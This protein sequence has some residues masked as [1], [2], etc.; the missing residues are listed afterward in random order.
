VLRGRQQPQPGKEPIGPSSKPRS[1]C[2]TWKAGALPVASKSER[3]AS[4]LTTFANTWPHCKRLRNF[5]PLARRPHTDTPT[6]V[7]CM[8]VCMYCT[9]LYCKFLGTACMYCMYIQ[10]VPAYQQPNTQTRPPR[11]GWPSVPASC[12]SQARHTRMGICA[13]DSRADKEINRQARQKQS[14]RQQHLPRNHHQTLAGSSLQLARSSRPQRGGTSG[15]SAVA[16]Q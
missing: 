5:R 12:F 11:T 3:S 1:G 8:Y 4:L 9:A 10:Y 7:L 6:Y 13:R 14:L 15:D 16:R 2:K